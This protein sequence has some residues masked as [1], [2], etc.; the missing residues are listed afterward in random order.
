MTNP[1]FAELF[2][3]HKSNPILS[4]PG[5]GGWVIDPQL[6]FSPSPT[7]HSE[8]IFPCGWVIEG[9]EVRLCYGTAETS[10]ALAT[11]SLKGLLEFVRNSPS[12]DGTK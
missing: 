1:Y 3:R 10:V 7:I 6:S 4:S 8:K 9:D 12:V 11:G 2:Q 5:V